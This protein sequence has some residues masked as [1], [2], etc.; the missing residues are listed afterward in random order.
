MSLDKTFKKK[1]KIG[2]V[3]A[4]PLTNPFTY[5]GSET[6]GPNF[7]GRYEGKIKILYP[8][9]WFKLS[10]QFTSGKNR[11]TI[12]RATEEINNIPKKGF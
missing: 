8:L 12:N 2:I 9:C 1:F 10:Y 5:N 3:N 7:F 11:D 6:K 4:I